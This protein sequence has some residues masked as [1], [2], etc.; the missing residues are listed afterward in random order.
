MFG[1]SAN[2]SASTPVAAGW[3]NARELFDLLRGYNVPCLVSC[4][5]HSP[6]NETIVTPER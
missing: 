3:R 4:A 5:S 2:G 6:S 1:L